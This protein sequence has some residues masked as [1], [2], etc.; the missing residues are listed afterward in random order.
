MPNGQPL[1]PKIALHVGPA[2]SGVLGRSRLDFEFIGAA[3]H[4]SRVLAEQ[5]PP[6]VLVATRTALHALAQTCYWYPC[7]SMLLN[8]TNAAVEV[9]VHTGPMLHASKHVAAMAAYLASNAGPKNTVM[10]LL[11]PPFDVCATMYGDGKI[12]LHAVPVMKSL[13]EDAGHLGEKAQALRAEQLAHDPWTL[14]FFDDHVDHAYEAWL[15]ASSRGVCMC[16]DGCDVRRGLC[17]MS[18]GCTCTFILTPTQIN[19][20]VIILRLVCVVLSISNLPPMLWV[21]PLVLC[22][23]P[24]YALL[25]WPA[26]CTKHRAWML[27]AHVLLFCLHTVHVLGPWML[28]QP[29]AALQGQRY[30]LWHLCGADTAMI[31]A[32]LQVFAMVV[33]VYGVCVVTRV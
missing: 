2:I 9:Y 18:T 11:S 30:F 26:T 20:L 28:T 12:P 1:Q 22:L 4:A 13:A 27:V 16:W 7:G 15:S 32:L 23:A 5:L 17:W 10:S 21:G 3:V 6:G 24:G 19:I 33:C 31:N 8:D 29:R 14:R 25:G